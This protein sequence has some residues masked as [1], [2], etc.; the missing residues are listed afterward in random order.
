M[1]NTYALSTT[2]LTVNGVAEKLKQPGEPDD[3][4]DNA[5]DDEREA[6]VVAKVKNYE[7]EASSTTKAQSGREESSARAKA[8]ENRP[9]A[10]RGMGDVFLPD[11]SGGAEDS[12]TAAKDRLMAEEFLEQADEAGDNDPFAQTMIANM[13]DL[14]RGL[15]QNVT[16]A[17]DYYAMAAAQGYAEATH[18]LGGAYYFGRGRAKNRTLAFEYYLRAAKLGYASSQLNVATMYNKGNG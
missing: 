15:E 12:S 4:D 14:G 7:G 6:I 5:D 8:R 2:G 11:V 18:N 10:K 16:K 3:S 1:V 9:I 13:Y 17:A